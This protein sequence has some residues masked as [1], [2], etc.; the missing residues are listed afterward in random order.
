M[1]RISPRTSPYFAPVRSW[2]PRVFVVFRAD[3]EKRIDHE[4]VRKVEL[5]FVVQGDDEQ[6]RR[7]EFA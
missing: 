7:G 6:T 2:V 1:R 4:P 3:V 5:A